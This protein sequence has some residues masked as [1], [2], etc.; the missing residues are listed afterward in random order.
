MQS[1]SAASS[2]VVNKWW[3]SFFRKQLRTSGHGLD[4]EPRCQWLGGCSL[5]A[6]ESLV[7]LFLEKGAEMEEGSVYREG[8]HSGTLGQ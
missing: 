2:G 7:G 6:G 4:G 1:A 8:G 3:R 5:E